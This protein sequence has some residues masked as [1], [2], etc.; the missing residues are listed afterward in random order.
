[1]SRRHPRGHMSSRA[2]R[3]VIRPARL[4]AGGSSPISRGVMPRRLA[5]ILLALVALALAA[6]TP[7]V[8]APGL[9]VA[10]QDDGHLLSD[11]PAPRAA[12]LAAG[13]QCGALSIRSNVAWASTAPSPKPR[14]APG[15]TVYDFARYDRLIAE[16][17]A[18]GLHLQLTLT[19]PAP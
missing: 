18:R 7:A 9:E 3:S 17:A 12:A 19:G 16:A 14:R 4:R 2:E 10:A 5:A 11:D 8:A 1:R 13:V 15:A 6:A